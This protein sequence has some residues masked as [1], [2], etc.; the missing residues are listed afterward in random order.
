MRG[1]FDSGVSITFIHPFEVAVEDWRWFGEKE[2]GEE[3]CLVN[4]ALEEEI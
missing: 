3:Y 2:E 1:L 4:G